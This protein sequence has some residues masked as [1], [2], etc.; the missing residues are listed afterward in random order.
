VFGGRLFDSYH[1]NYSG[2]LQISRSTFDR[3]PI[4][5][6]RSDVRDSLVLSEGRGYD[7]Q[8][9]YYEVFD[10]LIW[11][12]RDHP[13]TYRHFIDA[14]PYRFSRIGYSLLT[15]IVSLDRWQFY[16]ATMVWL[17]FGSIV[18]CAIV[19]GALAFE[20]GL[21]QA[22]GLLI[23]LI[24]GFWQS[25]QSAL[26]E[27]IAAATLLAGYLC[28]TRR[29]WWY[30]GI[31]FAI[32][33][34]IRETGVLF[35]LSVAGLGFISE[36][37]RDIVRLLVA[38]LSLI[39]LWKVYVGWRLFS[40]WGAEAFL[41]HPRD[42]DL[43]FSGVARLWSSVV[44]RL[45]YPGVPELSRAGVWYPLL[46]L[47][48]TV[49]AVVA[50]VRMPSAASVAALCYA[51]IAIS[52]NFDNMWVHVGNVE[53]GTFELFMMLAL[54]SLG[55]HSFS[56]TGRWSLMAFWASTAAYIF[57]SGID[58]EYIREAFLSAVLGSWN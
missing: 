16:P 21:T 43:P 12:F 44:H 27:P 39:I 28:V 18:L 30:A 15:K 34:T 38:S 24:P 29:Y 52:L 56:R 36:R 1:G 40:D 42:F 37:P 57:C 33:L 47:A 6:D 11:R 17:V 41:F 5:K 2:F 22:S 7:G 31:L 50:V 4:L 19:L 13:S 9:F 8:F 3:N 26:P 10:P 35:V 45:Y 25:L 14:P 49:F 55:F 20:G 53:R 54:V 46:L 48:A 58:A 32:S 51:A 23:V